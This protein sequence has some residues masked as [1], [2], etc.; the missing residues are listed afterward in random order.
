M[1]LLGYLCG[2][3]QKVFSAIQLLMYKFLVRPIINYAS[4]VWSPYRQCDVLILGAVKKKAAHFNFH[5]YDHNIS[6]SLAL[7]EVK[8]E[9][10]SVSYYVES[11]KYLH[12]L[13]NHS[14]CISNTPFLSFVQPSSTWYFYD[15]NLA[16][17][18]ARTDTFRYI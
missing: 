8:L 5:R 11:L 10:L 16:I 2:I 18:I 1:K 14:Y 15:L 6:P 17:L 9:P 3:T 4:T 13:M 12:N 7:H